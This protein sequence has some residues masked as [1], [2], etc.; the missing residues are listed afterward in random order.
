MMKFIGKILVHLVFILK[1]L[2]EL[3]ELNILVL[4]LSITR[5]AKERYCSPSS[6]FTYCYLLITQF[7]KTLLGN[8]HY[9][10]SGE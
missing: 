3:Y 9:S 5:L 2:F 8:M 7:G 10:Y 1:K 6:P 4:Y